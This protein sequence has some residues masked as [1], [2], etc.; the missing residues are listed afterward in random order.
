MYKKEIGQSKASLVK[1]V[2]NLYPK[3]IFKLLPQL[4]GSVS[5]DFAAAVL[6]LATKN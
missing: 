6:Y 1:S 4:A 5:A 2:V 3:L